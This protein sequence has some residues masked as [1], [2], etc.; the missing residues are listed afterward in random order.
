MHAQQIQR[1]GQITVHLAFYSGAK[2]KSVV[3]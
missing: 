1:C 2:T 3:L